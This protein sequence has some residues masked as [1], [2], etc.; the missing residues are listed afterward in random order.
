MVIIDMYNYNFLIGNCLK[1][2]GIG[3]LNYYNCEERF[4]SGC[5]MELYIDDEIYKC[6]FFLFLKC[7]KNIFLEYNNEI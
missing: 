5:L 2:D 4:V 6:M 7:F 3:N 1:L